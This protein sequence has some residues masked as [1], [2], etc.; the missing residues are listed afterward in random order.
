MLFPA[1]LPN[2]E[3]MALR[4][5]NTTHSQGYSKAIDLWSVGC[6]TV[7]LLTGETPFGSGYACRPTQVDADDDHLAVL[8]TDPCWEGVGR[9]PK[10][11]IR[12][13]LV[14]NEASRL[15]AKQ[16][17]Q[18]DWLSNK[19]YAAEMQAAYQ[20]AIQDWTP[21]T[22]TGASIVY[23]HPADIPPPASYTTTSRHFPLLDF[24]LP[25]FPP[26]PPLR[27]HPAEPRAHTPLP[28]IDDDVLS[29][30]APA[31]FKEPL[32]CDGPS[33]CIPSTRPLHQEDNTATT[34]M[35]LDAAARFDEASFC[36]VP[37]NQYA[38]P[39]GYASF[40]TSTFDTKKRLAVQ[41]LPD[42]L[43]GHEMV[44]R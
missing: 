25:N 39:P 44:K 8:D 26:I 29:L 35:T 24:Q 13:C 28:T 17:L 23:L 7:M 16:A 18:H 6:L 12:G 30:Q 32:P 21:R 38:L 15:T 20:R 31:S 5:N 14:K 33:L 22:Q 3:V 19:Q 9:K 10:S 4:T 2:S 1:D 41:A 34:Q 42:S 40:L 36:T 11:F 37:E 43:F 27:C